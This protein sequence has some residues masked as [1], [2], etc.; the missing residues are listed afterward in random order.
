MIHAIFSVAYRINGE[1]FIQHFSEKLE[2]Q[3]QMPETLKTK[4]TN[5]FHEYCREIKKNKDQKPIL[6]FI[7]EDG[8]YSI[9]GDPEKNE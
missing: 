5:T 3:S 4:I 8:S 7:K 2:E 1:E 6:R 9:I